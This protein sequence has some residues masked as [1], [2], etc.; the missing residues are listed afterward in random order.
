MKQAY[1]LALITIISALLAYS[2]SLFL[3]PSSSAAMQEYETHYQALQHK[4]SVTAA[5]KEKLEQ[6]FKKINSAENIKSAL[7]Q[8]ITKYVI[9][10]ILF[11]PTLIISGRKARLN[12]DGN[13]YASGIIF[14][15][16][17]LSGSVIIGAIAGSI[18]FFTNHSASLPNSQTTSSAD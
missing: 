5:D 2:S 11:I 4:Q 14:L 9:F 15:T 18:F 7:T 17:I 13:L 3:Q 10:F 1:K 6:L 8:D 12:K 16:F